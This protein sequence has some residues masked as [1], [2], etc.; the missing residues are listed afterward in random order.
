M[1]DP[2]ERSR[3][4]FDQDDAVGESRLVVATDIGGVQSAEQAQA[5]GLTAA[6]A[7][8]VGCGLGEHGSEGFA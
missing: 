1:W 5:G 3:P 8:R 4:A 7:L 6:L 2:A